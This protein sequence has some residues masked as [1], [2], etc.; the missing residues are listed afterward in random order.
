MCSATQIGSEDV[1]EPGRGRGPSVPWSATTAQ[2]ITH[3]IFFQASSKCPK[4]STDYCDGARPAWPHGGAPKDSTDY[5]EL[6]RPGA[7]CLA[8]CG[9]MAAPHG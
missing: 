5:C 6:L 4:D 2:Q 9:C 3:S 8:P 7:A 1:A